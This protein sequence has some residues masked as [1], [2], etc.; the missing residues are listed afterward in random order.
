MQLHNTSQYAIRVLNFFANHS[1]DRLYSAK[2]LAELLSIPYKFLTKIMGILVK[3][4]F[5]KSIQGREGGYELNKPAS[6]IKLIDILNTFNDETDNES[7]ILGVGICDGHNKCALHD[8]WMQPKGLLRKMFE[9][10]T[11][12]NLTS[13]DC[14]L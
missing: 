12:E 4:E 3:A 2:E 10:T 9:E 1:D 14:K 8:Q 11:L 6:Q 5:I 7:C 13:A